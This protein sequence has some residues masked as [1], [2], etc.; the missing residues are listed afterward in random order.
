MP[1]FSLMKLGKHPP[2]ID[3]R[4]LQ[5]A[6]YMRAIPPAPVTCDWT[7]GI[8]SW[9]MCLNGPNTFGPPVPAEGLGDCTIAACTHASTGLRAAAGYGT[10]IYPDWLT[11]RYYVIF[12]GYVYGNPN[13][14]QGGICL[15]V[16]NRW[17]ARGYGYRPWKKVWRRSEPGADVLT[18]YAAVNPANQ[19]EVMNC[20]S[21]FGGAYIG[22]M[23]P[24]TAMNQNLWAVVGDGSTGPSAPGTWGG[25]CV[26]VV[27]YTQQYVKVVTW[28]Q[29]MMMTWGFWKA[30][31]DEAYAL[32]SPDF[33]GVNKLDPSGFDMPTLLSDLQQVTAA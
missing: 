28:G 9:G 26:W 7:S 21:L 8:T 30:Y 24:A 33:L 11:L 14:D 23:L 1:D 18:A 12:D 20:V 10:S 29:I 27:G 19:V 32:V 3:P 15:Q 2:K 4:T 16:L 31:V 6:K 25:H 13:T 5:L 22:L 17:R